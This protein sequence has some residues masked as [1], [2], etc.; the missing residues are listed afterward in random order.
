MMRFPRIPGA[1]TTAMRAAIGT[2]LATM[3]LVAW[4][5]VTALRA[6]DEA[7]APPRDLFRPPA[8]LAA[9]PV[10]ARAALDDDPF[11]PERQ[12]PAVR[13]RLPGV[14]D[15]TPVADKPVLPE[16]LGTVLATD[17]QNLATIRL[18]PDSTKILRVGQKIGPY[19]VKEIARGQVTFTKASGEKLVVHAE[20]PFTRS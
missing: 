4:S 15:D 3:A 20:S 6:D 1:G 19:T 9:S 13:Y 5:A 8:G 7:V 14:E 10:P 18:G 11:S 17:G 12:P 16:V 2:L